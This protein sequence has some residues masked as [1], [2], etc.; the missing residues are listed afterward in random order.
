MTVV[1]LVTASDSL[2]AKYEDLLSGCQGSSPCY[3]HSR[4]KSVHD[5]RL[6]DAAPERSTKRSAD[7]GQQRV[8]RVVSSRGRGPARHADACPRVTSR[9]GRRTVPATPQRSAGANRVRYVNNNDAAGNSGT[10]DAP[11]DTLAQAETASGAGDTVFVFDGDNT[12]TGYGGDGYAMNANER[13]IGEVTGLVVGGTTLAFPKTG[14][15]PTITATNA[16]VVDLNSGNEVRGLEIDPEGT[17][18][19]IA[20]GTGDTGG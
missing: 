9:Y 7:R 8:G 15:R 5:R 10:S 16:D 14:A 12:S 13:L 6:S 18:G 20:G 17:G 4:T 1:R 2:Y 19:G 3:V 11:F